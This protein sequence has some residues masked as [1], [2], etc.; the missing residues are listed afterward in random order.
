[1]REGIQW[2]EIMMMDV[3]SV[4]EYSEILAWRNQEA[5]EQR[6]LQE[7]EAWLHRAQTR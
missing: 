7:S 3:Q 2:R 1:M 4:I 6:E 5:Q